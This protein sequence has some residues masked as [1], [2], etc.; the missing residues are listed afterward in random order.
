MHKDGL[1]TSKKLQ[2]SPQNFFWTD[3]FKYSFHTAHRN[4]KIYICSCLYLRRNGEQIKSSLLNFQ[5]PHCRHVRRVSG[6]PLSWSYMMPIDDRMAGQLVVVKIPVHLFKNAISTH[7][8]RGFKLKFQD[9]FPSWVPN[10][11]L[12]F[13][14]IILFFNVL[15]RFFISQF[16]GF[17]FQAVKNNSD[18]M[19]SCC[20]I[21]CTFP[22]QRGIGAANNI[23]RRVR[24]SYLG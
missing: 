7:Y 18:Q 14:S 2:K 21:R 8:F 19:Y 1:V 3:T 24:Y 11:K 22:Y 13:H 23:H 20:C 10:L 12:Q 16:I 5:I 15:T 9:Q 4:G 17:I 6:R